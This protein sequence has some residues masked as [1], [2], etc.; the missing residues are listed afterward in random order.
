MSVEF[1]VYKGSANGIVEAN[2]THAP[3]TG[4]QV[5]VKISHSGVCG[6]DEHYKQADMVL[7]HEGV[8]T[9]EQIGEAVTDLKVG[10]VVGWGYVNK[11]CGKCEQCLLGRDNYCPTREYYGGANFHQGSFGSRAIWDAEFL[12]KIP[13]GVKP[14]HAAPLMCGGATIFELVETYNIRPT[15]RVGVVGIG[16]LG[17]LAIIFLA[18]MG[19]NVVVFSSTES[20]REEALRLGASEFIAT[21]GLDK[22]DIPQL[23][24]LIVTTSFLPNWQP[25]LDAM[26]PRGTIFPLTISFDNLSIPTL[27]LVPRGINL[28]GSA[29]A[30]RSVQK[31]MLEF[32]ARHK[33]EPIVELFPLTK[34]GVEEGMQR[35]R[36]GKVRYRAVLVAKD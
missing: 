30:S 34:G 3:P 5:L 19:A 28:Q 14:E 36:D 12:F 17:H 2:T 4:N 21:Q 11:T 27:A 6:T 32:A 22:F 31:R 20:K 15:S 25:Y 33:V 18:K 1:T 8:G 16:G 35:L 10:D 24:F 7:G 29:V 13:E 23:D 26:K 9:V